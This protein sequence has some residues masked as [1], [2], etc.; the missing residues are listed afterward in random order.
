MCCGDLERKEIQKGMD[1]RMCLMFHFAMQQ[2]LTQRRK[3]ATLQ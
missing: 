3:A 2:K 1:R